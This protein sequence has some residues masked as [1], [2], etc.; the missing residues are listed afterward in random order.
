ML[1]R[2]KLD[3]VKSAYDKAIRSALRSGFLQNA[4]L[5]E[6]RCALFFFDVGDTDNAEYYLRQSYGHYDEWGSAAKLHQLN[7]RYDF[8]RNSGPTRRLST[9][10]F[11]RQRYDPK[12]SEQ[13]RDTSTFDFAGSCDSSVD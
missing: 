10:R 3:H 13:H 2:S 4:A 11:G 9:A 8:M 6:E 7:K 5:A 1:F 12:A